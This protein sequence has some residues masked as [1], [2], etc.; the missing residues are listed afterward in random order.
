MPE[1]REVVVTGLGLVLPAGR[2]RAGADAAFEG[3]CAVAFLPSIPGLPG[4]T[5]ADCADFA[6]PPGTETADRA[7][8]LAVAA[9]EDALADAGLLE[10][11][12]A[13]DGQATHATNAYG[14]RVAVC[15]SL[16]KGAMERPDAWR[17]PLEAA[18]D[19]AARAV[20]ARFGVEGP[21]LAPV[22]ACVSG[23]HAVMWAAR[24]I[25]RGVCD[26][27]LAGAA[28]A[29]LVPLVLGSYR[30]MGVLAPPG[31]DPAASVRPFS[32]SRQGFALGAGAGVLVL[33][34]REAAEARGAR[35]LAVLE[36]WAEGSQATS[37]TAVEPDGGSLAG[38]IAR[39]LERA[40]LAPAEIDY[41]AAHGTATPSG[42]LAEARAIGAAL[43][44]A[45]E[46]VSVS[47]T[48]GSHGHLLG[49][50]AAVE[51]AL[52]VLAI[53]RGQIPA[54]ANLRDPD[55]SLGLT[56]AAEPQAR[57]VRHALK[58]AAGFGGQQMAL[59]LGRTGV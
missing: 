4:I 28:E 37:L 9:A 16:S 51:T 5:G 24:L 20:A 29:S 1:P 25:R 41:V 50:A 39:A 21:A 43:G 17:A 57:T 2:G 27:A 14:R 52:A 45:T 19:V 22:S 10:S 47:S 42:D 15:V 13:R 34:A 12:G 56:C 11:V 49:A 33:E 32:R 58:L 53:E 38:L 8:Q 6:P 23:G 48:K 35:L 46:G 26:A 40:G 54:T 36:A 7:V 30:R 3:R 31:D 44:P 55:P 18:P 59:V